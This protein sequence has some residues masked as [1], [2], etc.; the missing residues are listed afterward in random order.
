MCLEDGAKLFQVIFRGRCF[1]T[2]FC[3]SFVRVGQQR[4]TDA[5]HGD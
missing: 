3:E 5:E 4:W 2:A 1:F